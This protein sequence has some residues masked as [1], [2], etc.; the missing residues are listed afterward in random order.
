MRPPISLSKAVSTSDSGVFVC[1]APGGLGAGFCAPVFVF[2]V[3]RGRTFV[4]DEF[5]FCANATVESISTNETMK[6][7]LFSI[8]WLLVIDLTDLNIPQFFQRVKPWHAAAQT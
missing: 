4:G 2:A 8:M 1:L 3:V 7:D 5:E 6:T